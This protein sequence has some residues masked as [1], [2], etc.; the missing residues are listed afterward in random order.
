MASILALPGHVGERHINC[1]LWTG[2][3]IQFALSSTF[4]LTARQRQYKAK[5]NTLP[6]VMEQVAARE[7]T[8]VLLLVAW[9]RRAIA[10][11]IWRWPP[12]TA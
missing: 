9:Q 4:L 2:S 12:S 11:S 8:A 7:W 10:G 6:L 1:D 5:P 3:F